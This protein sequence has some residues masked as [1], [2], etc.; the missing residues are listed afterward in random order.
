MSL[1]GSNNQ[2]LLEHC[3]G[4]AQQDLEHSILSEQA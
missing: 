2:L 1:F 4:N 3:T